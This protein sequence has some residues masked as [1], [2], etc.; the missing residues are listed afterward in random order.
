MRIVYQER[1][2]PCAQS[3]MAYAR[4]RKLQDSANRSSDHWLAPA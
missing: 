4:M 1:F 3:T 2:S